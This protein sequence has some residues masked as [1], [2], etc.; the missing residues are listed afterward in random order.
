MDDTG[1][2]R[3]GRELFM[4]GLGLPIEDVDS[5]VMDRMIAVLEEQSVRAGQ[6]IYR[7]GEPADF[8]YF[9]R[10][11]RLRLSREGSPSWSL[12]GNWV[13]GSLEAMADIPHPRTATA[14]VDF[15]MMRVPVG[16]WL[17]LLED[18]FQ[19]ARAGITNAARSVALLEERITELPRQERRAPRAFCVKK[20]PQLSLVERLAFLVEIRMLRRAGVQTLGDLAGMSRESAFEAGATVLERAVERSELLL[21]I[22]G[23]VMATRAGPDVV[24]HYGAGDLVCGAAAFGTRAPFWEAKA[25]TPT[26]VLSFPIE[27]WFDLMEEH[28][29]LVRSTFEALMV[30]R[31]VLLEH[32]ASGQQ[33]L[34]LS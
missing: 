14:L 6:V 7:A 12:E 4:V 30:R 19:A 1:L 21:V 26:R 25:V 32:L 17:E 22:D 13:I 8:L 2:V 29:D 11:G 5:W 9:V 16:A 27:V 28:F 10:D 20:T 15:G 31:E 24:R 33:E 23:E 34:V 18:S 3:L